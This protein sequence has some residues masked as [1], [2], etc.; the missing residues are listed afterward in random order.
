MVAGSPLNAKADNEFTVTVAVITVT[1]ITVAKVLKMMMIEHSLEP[2]RYDGSCGGSGDLNVDL[3]FVNVGT[4]SA[5]VFMLA[6]IDGGDGVS[7]ENDD[8]GERKEEDHESQSK[9]E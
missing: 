2:V 1:G 7:H 8:G 4:V 3:A 5:K 6:T 9:K